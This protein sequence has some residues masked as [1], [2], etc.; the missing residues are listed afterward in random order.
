MSMDFTCWLF[1][2]HGRS[3]YWFHKLYISCLSKVTIGQL[4]GTRLNNNIVSHSVENTMGFAAVKLHYT[5]IYSLHRGL[6]INYK[7]CWNISNVKRAVKQFQSTNCFPSRS[8]VSF[9]A[10]IAII[11]PLINKDIIKN[12]R[13]VMFEIMLNVIYGM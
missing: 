12:G 7:V 4:A 10:I 8:Y 13:K 9:R 11:E 5:V 3:G 2:K 1:D 6:K